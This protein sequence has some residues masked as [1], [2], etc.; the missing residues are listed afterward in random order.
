LHSPL[1]APSASQLS[2]TLTDDGGSSWG[3]E[4][5]HHPKKQRR[6]EKPIS[7]KDS[8]GSKADSEPSG[9]SGGRQLLRGM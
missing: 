3:R 9:Q 4:G 7:D 6:A 2:S 1:S 5:G 8:E